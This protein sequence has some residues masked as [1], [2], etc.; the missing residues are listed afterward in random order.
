MVMQAFDPGIV[1]V[2]YQAAMTLQDAENAINYYVEVA[3][4]DGAKEPVAL[5][6]TPGKQPILSTIAGQGRGFWVLPGGLQALYVVGNQLFLINVTAPATQTSIAQ[7]TATMVGTLLT[8]SGPVVM[9]DNG[10]ISNGLGGFVLIVDGVFGY[11]YLI[12]GMPQ[13]ATFSASLSIGSNIVTFPGALPKGLIVANTPTLSDTGGVIPANTTVTSI[14][15]VGLTLTMSAPASGNSFTDTVTLTIPIFGKITDPGFPINPQRILFIEGWLAVNQ[16]GSRTFNLNGPTPYSMT[17]PGL[18]FA[19]KDSS[20]DNLVTLF[21]NNREAWMIGERTSEV[22][23]NNSGANVNFPF[24]RVPGVGPQM[25]CSAVHSITR[26]GQNLAWLAKNEQGENIVV[27]T[28]QYSVQRISNQAI[29]NAISS[30]PVVSDA[31]G[32]CYEESGHTFYVLIFPTADNCWVYDATSSALLGQPCWHQRLSFDPNTGMY[33][34]DRS[35]CFMDFQD[36]RLVGD[37]QTGQIHNMTRS[38]YTDAGNPLRA[39]RR[40]KHIW[41]KSD[42]TRVRQSSIQLEFTPGVGLQVGQGSSPQCMMRWSNDGGFSWSNEH[43]RS[44]G[45]AGDTK[46]RAK[47]NRLG[48]ARDRVYEL[49]FSD[50]TPRDIIGATLFAE[51]EDAL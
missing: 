4:V 31:I 48:R 11:Y 2:S 19:L 14:D 28:Q 7:L 49:N 10:V 36:L 18:F 30:Y 9:R 23:F 42:R 13:L 27:Q 22:W 47:W 44:I 3:E 33:H 51:S 37:Y 17:F 29:E 46:N 50:P 34:R 16:G 24:S 40:C 32:Y 39:Q 20:T 6:G 25:G 5:L 35:N 26:L 8:N 15:T 1:G 12:S 21:E 45:A 41:K 43:W 38:V